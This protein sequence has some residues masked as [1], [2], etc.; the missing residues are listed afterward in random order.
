MML[1]IV[2]NWMSNRV[3]V[4]TVRSGEG[5]ALR[6]RYPARWYLQRT[7]KRVYPWS[8]LHAGL[9]NTWTLTLTTKT[10][11]PSY[12]V[13]VPHPLATEHP[14]VNV[15]TSQTTSHISLRLNP[16]QAQVTLKQ[17]PHI[18]PGTTGHG[19]RADCT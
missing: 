12:P 10:T 1:L 19:D 13:G 6:V 5:S 15:I 4:G 17:L 16:S 11:T 18:S 3:C 2:G 14:P 9:S 7:R 8:K